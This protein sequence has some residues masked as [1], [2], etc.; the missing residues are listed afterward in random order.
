[1]RRFASMPRAQRLTLALLFAVSI[2]A[3]TG[4]WAYY[5][6]SEPAAEPVGATLE[7]APARG[8]AVVSAVAAGSAAERAG[9]RAGDAVTAVNGQ[10][11][12]SLT[13]YF[14]A[15]VRGQ[16]GDAVRFELRSA[17]GAERTVQLVLAPRR[18][19]LPADT[20]TARLASL[21]THSYPFV[22]LVV[23]LVVL[24][25]RLDDGHA[26]LLAFVF[27][28]FIAGPEYQEIVPEFHT[29]FRLAAH[30]YSILLA[31]LGPAVFY[32]F[33][34][35]FPVASP[36]ERRAPWLKWVALAGGAAFT[37]PCVAAALQHNSYYPFYVRAG[38]VS[39]GTF[40]LLHRTNLFGWVGLGFLALIG[41]VLAT[42]DPH[43]KR[44]IRV[45][46]WGTLVGFAPM[47]GTYF[48]A[49]A[50]GRPLFSEPAVRIAVNG[51]LTLVPV[52]MA[53]AV[54]KHRVLEM[55]MLLKRSA[56]YLLV[57]GSFAVVMTVIAVLVPVRFA[58][59]TAQTLDFPSDAIAPFALLLGVA[60]GMLWVAGAGEVEKRIMPRI[61][62]AFFRSVYDAR[63][64]LEE[65]A[66]RAR[67]VAS[68]EQLSSLLRLQIHQ[69]LHPKSIA[70]YFEAAE[71]TLQLQEP[72][73]RLP[74]LLRSS[75]PL[76]EKLASHGRPWEV[77][78]DAEVAPAWPHRAARLQ[79]A[80]GLPVGLA[81]ERPHAAAAASRAMITALAPAAPECL[82]PLVGR[83]S[84]LLGLIVLGERRSEEPYSD[85]DERLLASVAGQAATALE[86]MHLAESM[87]EK[88]E[89]ERKAAAEI[90]IAREVQSRLFPQTHPPM[91]TI[92]YA[93]LCDQAR[94]VGG[95]YFDFLDLGPGR[96]GLALADISGK[97]I[98]AALLMANLQANLRSQYARAQDDLPGLMRSV[99]RLFHQ[100]T[101]AGL[102][103]TMF[104]ADYSDATRR[105][106]YVNCG[107]NPPLLLR[108]DGSHARL[109]STATV[110]GL[111]EPWDCE[112]GEAELR[113]GDLL[114]IYSDGATEAQSDAGEFFGEE[115]LLQAARAQA[116]LPIAEAA[117]AIAQAVH[118]FSETTQEDDLTL[119]VARAL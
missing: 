117:R 109:E 110:I 82:V 66:Q 55:P 41:S 23:G 77:P 61:D 7:E 38:W 36:I 9:L 34:A 112:V 16:P 92:E 60:F 111:L 64:I 19:V 99:N 10:P 106:R 40:A 32:I 31:F 3:Y 89:G 113:L 4:L 115:R 58:N 102:Y 51:L 73:E 54:V 100:S 1:M 97:G 28:C 83:D 86:N 94:K 80:A 67:S 72:A 24:F 98:Y 20:A 15:V 62:R 29:A 30:G 74:G 87:A 49:I 78:A 104:F 119:L 27:A 114:V 14:D 70:I 44:R 25:Q 105:L 13:P 75:E 57:R 88:L 108:A 5:M 56:R 18:T 39:T 53:Y 63:Q 91:Q 103:A 84:R 59:A 11:L 93:G 17:D 47:L 107:H 50:T 76:L 43:A 2:A 26:W 21:L 45:I 90:A 65:L 71:G 33:F 37:L 85:E 8:V 35:T 42:R 79:S 101:S 6:F 52:A 48:L 69:A 96:I 46:L 95:D 118:T 12:D 116:H 22:F 68:R 81:L